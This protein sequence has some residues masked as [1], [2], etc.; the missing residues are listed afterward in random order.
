MNLNTLRTDTPGCDNI[1]HLNNAGAALMPR[2]VVTTIEQ[3]LKEE[4]DFGGYETADKHAA[5]LS[6]FY[7]LTAQLLQTQPRNIAFT[8]NAT[9]S[10]NK[11]LTAVPFEE[12]DVVLLTENDYPSNF[13]SLISLQKRY[14]IKLVL[15]KNAPNG[16]VDL[17]DLEEKLRTYHPKLV[18]ITHIPTSSGLIQPAEAAGEI[19]SKYDTLYLLDACQS[20]GQLP[21]TAAATKADFI[22]GT[23]RKWLR[24]PRGTGLLYVSDKALDMGL[25]PL[26]PDFAGATWTGPFSYTHRNDAKRFELWEKSQALQMGTIAALKYLL[27]LGIEN[28]YTRCQML[29]AELRLALEEVPGV[30]LQDRGDRLSA[31]ITFTVDGK[32]EA[33]AKQFFRDRGINIYTTS[34]PSA[35]IDF[36]EKGIDWV[37]RVS[38]HYYND[39]EE[40]TRFLEVLREWQEE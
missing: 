3:Y 40:L 24:G 28:V 5:D 35:V 17:E 10:Y 2:P 26:L 14:G 34:K 38:P 19:I 29:A 32:Q 6:T 33:G 39:G 31:I 4:A 27:D 20:L 25:E 23:A 7:D 37:M 22:S 8:T 15:V 21:V 18:S 12:G 36:Q 16:E 9:D 11:A 30:K 13:I 1:I